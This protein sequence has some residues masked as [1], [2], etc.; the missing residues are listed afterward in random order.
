MAA[1]GEATERASSITQQLLA[2]GQRSM[3]VPSTFDA[4]TLTR[5]LQDEA[6]E[7]LPRTVALRLELAQSLPVVRTDRGRLR[8]VIVQLCIRAAGAL[9]AGGTLTISTGVGALGAGAPAVVIRVSDTGEPL[10]ESD[11]RDFLEPF[12]GPLPTGTDSWSG[13]ELAMAAGFM[14][15]IGGEV[16]V[17]SEEGIGTVVTLVIPAGV[18][19]DDGAG[20]DR[21]SG[22]D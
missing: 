21:T 5:D 13:L 7:V 10:P 6:R 9:S 20:P 19:E 15:Q 12:A 17:E 4:T 1:I 14:R 18:K 11:G 22:G 16:T 3:L 2:F 8:E